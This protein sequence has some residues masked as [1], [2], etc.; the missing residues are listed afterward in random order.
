MSIDRDRNELVFF[1]EED[2]EGL[3]QK[4]ALN[5]MN[6]PGILK[7]HNHKKSQFTSN[8]MEHLSQH[9]TFRL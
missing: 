7:G 8:I 6:K 4:C 5:Y 1:I 9:R 3:Y 2:N